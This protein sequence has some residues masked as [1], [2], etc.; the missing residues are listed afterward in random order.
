MA[1]NTL[2]FALCLLVPDL[3]F[4]QKHECITIENSAEPFQGLRIE[5]LGTPLPELFQQAKE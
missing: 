4:S 5:L 2:E 1:A 3:H